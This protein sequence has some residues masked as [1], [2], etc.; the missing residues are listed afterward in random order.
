ME[1]ECGGPA[2]LIDCHG[3][4]EPGAVGV[5]QA[6]IGAAQVRAAQIGV[7]EYRVLRLRLAQIGTAQVGLVKSAAFSTVSTRRAPRKSASMQRAS[8]RSPSLNSVCRRFTE[9]REALVRLVSDRVAD[10]MHARS[11]LTRGSHNP[12]RSARR[13][14]VRLKLSHGS[15]R[16]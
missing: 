12:S 15:G 9:T 16:S 10:S 7:Q 11:R 13:S 1:V 5:G 8:M 2:C 14:S 3:R 6:E 4:F